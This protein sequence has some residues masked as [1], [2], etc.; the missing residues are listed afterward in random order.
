[1]TKFIVTEKSGE[2]IF[3]VQIQWKPS[4]ANK[5]I[6]KSLIQPKFEL[7]QDFMPVLI[8][9]KFD[10]NLIKGNWENRRHLLSHY[11]SIGAFCCHGNQFWS[12]L[13]QNWMHP[14]PLPKDVTDKIWL[15][16]ANWSWR[17]FCSKVWT[18]NGRT[19]EPCLRLRWDKHMLMKTNAQTIKWENELFYM[20]HVMRKPVYAIHA[21]WSAPL[22]FTA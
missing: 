7:V 20:S 10:K 6:V 18:D 15:K 13:P 19:M 16:L 11:L 1:M 9:C 4:R 14:F 8:T 22:L 21:V 3:P 17:Y 5:S 2:T 12:D